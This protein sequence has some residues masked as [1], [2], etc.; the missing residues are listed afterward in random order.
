LQV[1]ENFKTLRPGNHFDYH[2]PPNQ[3]VPTQALPTISRK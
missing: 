1:L 3:S 2:H